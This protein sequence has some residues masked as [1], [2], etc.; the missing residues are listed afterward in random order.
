LAVILDARTL[1]SPPES[2][3]R[4]SYD[5]HKRKWGSKTYIAVDTLGHLVAKDCE[6]LPETLIGLHLLAFVCVPL[7]KAEPLLHVQST[8][9][10]GRRRR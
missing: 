3:A 1:Q 7:Q 8:L 9:S 10:S 2:G 6:R 5:G 4:A